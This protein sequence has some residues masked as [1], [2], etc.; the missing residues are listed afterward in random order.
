M[1]QS[2]APRM[3]LPGPAFV[4]GQ[5][6]APPPPGSVGNTGETYGTQSRASWQPGENDPRQLCDVVKAESLWRFSAFGAVRISIIY[7]TLASRQ[8]L[9]LLAPVVMTIPG[10]FTATAQPVD[11]DHEGVSCDITLTPA[12]ASAL[13][14]ARSFIDAGAGPALELELG[15][16]RYVA[17]TNSTLTISG[18]AVAVPALSSVPLVAGALLNTGSGF[19]EFEA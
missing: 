5:P 19:Q 12:T 2:G 18:A 1:I 4:S 16:V 17:L 15:A 13:E 10:Q 8:I 6:A 3:V 14:H 9:N 11:E 7:G